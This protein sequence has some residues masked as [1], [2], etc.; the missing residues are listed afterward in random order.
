MYVGLN[1]KEEIDKLLPK[2]IKEDLSTSTKKKQSF[3][4]DLFQ[5]IK[6]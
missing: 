6:S 5:N 3:K 1:N 4:I 2:E